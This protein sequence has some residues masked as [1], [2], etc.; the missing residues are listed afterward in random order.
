MH[1]GQLDDNNN[2]SGSAVRSDRNRQ[3]GERHAGICLL[4]Y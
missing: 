1:A 4:P 3:S 2:N